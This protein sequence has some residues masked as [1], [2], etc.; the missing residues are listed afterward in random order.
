MAIFG[1]KD[2][3]GNFTINFMA[4][5]DTVLW[6]ELNAIS[7]TM[8][9]DKLEFKNRLNKK[10]DPIYLEYE[11]VTN[12]VVENKKEI[13]EKD[14]SVIKRGIVGGVLL[15]P[16]GAVIGAIDGTGSKKK[17][18]YKTFLVFDYISRDGEEKSLPVEIVGATMGLNKFTK[19]L[20]N[21]CPNLKKSN[22]STYL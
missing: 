21:K 15:G 13:V 8:L 16:I 4:V 10:K 6:D 2:R 19:E 5:K 3:Q 18:S 11:K 9:D 7:I 14:K 17:V 22:E 20:E 12:F 1:N